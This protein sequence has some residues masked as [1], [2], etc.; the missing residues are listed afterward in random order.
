MSY[1]K[2][3]KYVDRHQAV[4]DETLEKALGAS[5]ESFGDIAQ[6]SSLEYLFRYSEHEDEKT[7]W[8]SELAPKG[9]EALEQMKV[10]R[11]FGI[12]SC[13]LAA[14]AAVASVFSLL[15]L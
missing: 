7:I 5:I 14:I 3:L 13:V 2:L 6:G 15:P 1:Y 4:D 11:F 9:R 12:L 10:T 8:Y